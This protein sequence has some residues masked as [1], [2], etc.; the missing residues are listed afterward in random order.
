MPNFVGFFC[1]G[2]QSNHETKCATRNSYADKNCKSAHLER[3]RNNIAFASVFNVNIV[4]YNK[5]LPTK[6][7]IRDISTQLLHYKPSMSVTRGCVQTY[8]TCQH[9]QQNVV[10]VHFFHSFYQILFLL[11]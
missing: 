5:L 6:F 3:L 1:R 10:C 4:C 11:L 7:R 9:Q 8:K 2:H